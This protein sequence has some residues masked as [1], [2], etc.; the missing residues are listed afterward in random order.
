MNIQSCLEKIRSKILPRV[1]ASITDVSVAIQN[2]PWCEINEKRFYQGELTDGIDRAFLFSFEDHL[3]LLSRH[4]TWFADG[5]FKIRPL[6][7]VFKQV[8]F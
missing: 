8:I 2:S 5:T 6:K 7:T 3:S 1:P 4:R